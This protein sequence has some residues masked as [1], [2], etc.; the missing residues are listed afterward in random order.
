MPHSFFMFLP[1]CFFSSHFFLSF[2][3]FISSTLLPLLFLVLNI[4]LQ[5]SL[6]DHD[7]HIEGTLKSMTNLEGYNVILTYGENSKTPIGATIGSACPLVI[8]GSPQQVEGM[9]PIA[10]YEISHFCADSLISN[11]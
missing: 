2:I 6:G 11:L 1:H 8:K 10:S 5:L 3:Y 9:K 4:I 7:L